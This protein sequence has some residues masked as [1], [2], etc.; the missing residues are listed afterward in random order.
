M[1]CFILHKCSRLVHV[2]LHSVLSCAGPGEL[3]DDLTWMG[4]LR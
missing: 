2:D 4:K 3:R 1:V